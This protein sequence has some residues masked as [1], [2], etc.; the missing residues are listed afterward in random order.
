M[1]TLGIIILLLLT[2]GAINCSDD[3]SNIEKETIDKCKPTEHEENKECINNTK[4]VD[5]IDVTPDNA[6]SL[7]I[8][9]EITWNNGMWSM[10]VNCEWTCNNGYIREENKCIEKIITIIPKYYIDSK[11]GDD[12][13]DGLSELTAW[14]TLEKVETESVNFIAGDIIGFKGG[15]I[16]KGALNIN[17]INGNSEHPIVFTSYGSGQA[18]ITNQTSVN[19][20]TDEGNNL[21]ATSITDKVYQ[22]FKGNNS[23]PIAKSEYM[24][25]SKSGDTNLASDDLS[26][27]T[28]VLN[29]YVHIYPRAWI[30][31][32][33]KVIAFDNSN[34]TFTLNSALNYGASIGDKFYVVND[35][36]Y[37]DEQDEWFYNE[38]TARL[39]IYSSSKP[40]N[41]NVV[42]NETNGINIYDS[43][44]IEIN[45]LEIS[46]V[47]D[48]GINILKSSDITIKNSS[49]NYCYIN[50]I[51]E[52]LYGVESKNSTNI[53]ILNNIISNTTSNS[54][55]FRSANSIIEGN[56]IINNGDLKNVTYLSRGATYAVSIRGEGSIIRNNKVENSAYLGISFF[57]KDMII[58]KNII[59]N[60]CMELSDGGGIYT[61]DGSH[62]FD[63]DGAA[64][65]IIKNNFI[66]NDIN[67]ESKFSINGIY[68]DD[69]THDVTITSNHI[70]NVKRGIFLH[71]TINCKVTNNTVH[72]VTTSA[73]GLGADPNSGYSPAIVDGQISGNIV[74]GNIFFMEYNNDKYSNPYDMSYV[75]SIGVK[76]P[77]T[78]LNVG[79]FDNNKIYNPYARRYFSIGSN[80]YFWRNN[81]FSTYQTLSWWQTVLGNGIN[82][83]VQDFPITK[84]NYITSIIGEELVPNG[85]FLNGDT[86]NWFKSNVLLLGGNDGVYDYMEVSMTDADAGVRTNNYDITTMKAN[87]QYEISF[88]IKSNNDVQLK[89]YV[90]DSSS[91]SLMQRPIWSNADAG[92]QHYSLP[93][94]TG[95]GDF[96]NVRVEFWGED[97][98]T[99]QIANISLKEVT[100]TITDDAPISRYYQNETNTV[101]T[102]NLET[103]DWKDLNGNTYNNSLTL[104][105]YTSIILIP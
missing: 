61:Y 19:S 54:I 23:L 95:E 102:I 69:R 63:G 53:S 60:F 77:W 98:N 9:T 17:N 94:T 51:K 34:G 39:Y 44:F 96:T 35:K 58:E 72:G 46:K 42:V 28:G 33:R 55:R 105:P 25:L 76:N 21:W 82:S 3:G 66:S 78:N 6:N 67:R 65:T 91:G 48:K 49:L 31:F 90:K 85:K 104:E 43:S 14:K 100:Y 11:N 32:T 47:N 103:G 88:D 62:S 8:K 22:V 24:V 64:G 68:L 45:N 26:G 97:I 79:T 15:E 5:C 93:A 36:Q 13:N 83:V 40:E 12:N 29:A 2:L 73:F 41:I 89:L 10:A 37:L 75:I 56:T 59:H 92:W 7:N 57:G 1:K 84:P 52:G 74:T 87:T 18:I 50:G 30:S 4:L 86:S 81:N 70:N 80:D 38:E 27:N 16:F 20:W 99:Y 71:N 101:K